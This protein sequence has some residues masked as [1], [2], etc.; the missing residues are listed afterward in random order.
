MNTNRIVLLSSLGA[1]ALLLAGCVTTE[2]GGDSTSSPTAGDALVAGTDYHATGTIPC[3]MGDGQPTG[4]WPF[5]VKREGNGSATV[6]VTKPDGR[7]RSIFFENGR[8]IDADVSQ[9][10]PGAFSASKQGDLQ[11]VLIGRER[12]EIPDAVIYGD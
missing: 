12:Y 8:A 10:D 3:S 6:T 11:I 4:N 2:T 7:T 1:G 9:A 5:G